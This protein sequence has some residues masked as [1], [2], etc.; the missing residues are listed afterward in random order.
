MNPIQEA[1]LLNAFQEERLVVS[2]RLICEMNDHLSNYL[3][4]KG[5]RSAILTPVTSSPINRF[6]KNSSAKE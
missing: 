5:N 4:L 6:S 1:N 2:T 3:I